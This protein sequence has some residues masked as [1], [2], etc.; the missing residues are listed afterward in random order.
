MQNV[1]AIFDIGKTNKKLFLFDEQYNIVWERSCICEQTTDEDGEPCEDLTRLTGFI[2]AS[3]AGIPAAFMLKAINFSAY[4]ASFVYIGNDG[5]PVAPLYN[6]LKPFPDEL[7]TKFYDAHGGEV[8]FS[9]LTA[10]PVLGSLNSGMQLYRIKELQ[11]Q[12]FAKIQTALHLP[13]YLSYLLTGTPCSDIT[14]IGC[15]TNLWNFSQQHY[16]EWVYREGIID[17][18][19]PILP[20]TSVL[21][22]K[23]ASP[24]GLARPSIPISGI[25]LHD[26]SA[27]MIPYFESF[28][29]PFLL[30]STGTWCISMNPFNHSPLTVAELQKD[31]LCYLSYQGK[32]VKASRLFAG[33]EH[34]QQVLRIAA[35]FHVQPA[36]AAKVTYD[37]DT[38]RQLRAHPA[39]KPTTFEE[40]YHRLMLDIMAKQ[41]ASTQLV[42]HDTDVKRIFVDGGFGKNQ[43]YMHLLAEAF[44]DIEVFAASIP[45]ATAIGA[46][47]AIHQHWND[48]SR[49]GDIIELKYYK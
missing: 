9:M 23:A 8:T 47:L 42:L 37:A 6:Y 45:Q 38:I 44:P 21:P 11:P 5:K 16:H 48:G 13:Q 40:A 25:G 41:V 35:E 36:T 39:D 31:C 1:I 30:I 24:P 33:Y 46:A 29:E 34:E 20:S 4:G 32:P 3:L 7:K 26:S 17:K 2:H 15:H 10:S 49:P 43:I 28:R 18:L 27:A 14:S 12:L 22:V 19:A